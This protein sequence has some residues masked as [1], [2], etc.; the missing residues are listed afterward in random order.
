ME[1]YFSP[2]GKVLSCRINKDPN[3][4]S[5]RGYGFV[6]FEAPVQAAGAIFALNGYMV[7]GKKLQVTLK[8]GEE[9]YR[10]DPPAN[11]P[12]PPPNESS[13]PNAIPKAR[14]HGAD[15]YDS[16]EDNNGG[17]REGKGM[18]NSYREG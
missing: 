9:L 11:V 10:V 2:Y 3:T 15:H 13:P 7:E 17:Y 6:S 14:S 5:H 1:N 12:M 16:M 4:G 18:D 8:K